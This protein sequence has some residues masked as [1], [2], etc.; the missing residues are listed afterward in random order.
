[1]QVPAGRVESSN[2][3]TKMILNRTKALSTIRDIASCDDTT[4][5]LG[6]EVRAMSKAET[7]NLLQQA[8]LPITVPATDALAMKADLAML[9]NKLRVLR[10]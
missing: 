6:A 1:M 7:R 3:C 9:W 2:A 5:P 4:L 10:R 8:H